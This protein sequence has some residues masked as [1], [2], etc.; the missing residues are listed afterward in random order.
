MRPLVRLSWSLDGGSSSVMWAA[1]DDVST[2]YPVEVEMS[3]TLPSGVGIALGTRLE[4]S[5]GTTF[6]VGIREDVLG[7][8]LRGGFDVDVRWASVDGLCSTFKYEMTP[9]SN[10]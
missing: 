7:R 6:T 10:G 9:A 3:T 4:M 8:A 2:L 5:T 1:P